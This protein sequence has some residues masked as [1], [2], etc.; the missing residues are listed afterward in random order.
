M[1]TKTETAVP[2]NTDPTS[3]FMH[4]LHADGWTY[5]RLAPTD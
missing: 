4:A 3:A 1:H 2:I 5:S